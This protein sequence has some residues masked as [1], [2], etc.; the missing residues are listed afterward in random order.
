MP[1]AAGLSVGSVDAWQAERLGLVPS[2]VRSSEQYM[3]ALENGLPS[4][5]EGPAFPCRSG[6]G[7]PL[8]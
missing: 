4:W 1:G 7:S 8:C 2:H 3:T 5:A 6:A